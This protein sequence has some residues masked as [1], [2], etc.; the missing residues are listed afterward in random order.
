MPSIIYPSRNVRHMTEHTLSYLRPALEPGWSLLDVGCGSG[1]VHAELAGE[2]EVR[3]LD[4]VDGRQVHELPF[5]LFDGVHLPCKDASYDVALL[6][7]VLH[8]VPNDIKPELLREVCRVTR[9]RVV[10]L[11]D[12]PRTP[13]D[14]L[15][16]AIHGWRVSR[17]IGKGASFG[18]FTQRGW[19][20]FFAANGLRVEKSLVIPR[21]QRHWWR[22]WARSC[23]VLSK[24]S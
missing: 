8:H 7:F 11:E 20:A 15:A 6:S 3:G 23:F 16:G 1:Y 10:V 2:R 13:F 9:Q 24:A 21:L 4:V 12:T 5:A 18:Y 17:D 22:P 19:E 14:W